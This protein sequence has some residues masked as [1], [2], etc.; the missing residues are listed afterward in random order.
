MNSS[1]RDL[2]SLDQYIERVS[3]LMRVI[4]NDLVTL[5][6]A[7]KNSGFEELLEKHINYHKI[8]VKLWSKNSD[9]KVGLKDVFNAMP[10][11]NPR[12]SKWRIFLLYLAASSPYFFKKNI[13]YKRSYKK[14]LK[15]QNLL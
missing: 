11:H 6:E 4:Y 1:S 3:F 14:Q 9:V 15:V 5:N 8:I 2:S 12:T 10:L 13:V 7:L